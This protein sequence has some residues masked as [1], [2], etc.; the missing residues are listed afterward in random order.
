MAWKGVD[1]LAAPLIPDRDG[2][3]PAACSDKPGERVVRHSIEETGRGMEG[4]Q[5]SG[6]LDVPKLDRTVATARHQAPAVGAECET[7]YLVLMPFEC[8]ALL[9][10]REA[11]DGRGVAAT[12]GSEPLTVGTEGKP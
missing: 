8:P 4:P 5:A 2:P 6:G 11:V 12:R 9:A 10:R 3:L 1:S 7:P